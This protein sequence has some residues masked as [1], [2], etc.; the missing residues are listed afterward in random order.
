MSVKIAITVLIACIGL[1]AALAV[2]VKRPPVNPADSY[3]QAPPS[4]TGNTLDYEGP[5]RTGSIPAVR[6]G[7][8]N[9]GNKVTIRI[10]PEKEAE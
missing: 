1:L 7:G 4:S 10:T 5:A 9:S 3:F 6:M 2:Y 8:G